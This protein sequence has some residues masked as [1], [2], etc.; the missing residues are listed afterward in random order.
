M[1]PNQDCGA[2]TAGCPEGTFQVT[3]NFFFII[4]VLLLIILNFSVDQ[5]EFVLAGF[6]FV[7]TGILY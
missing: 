7:I 4:M 5:P 1:Q 2:K 6:L 3:Y